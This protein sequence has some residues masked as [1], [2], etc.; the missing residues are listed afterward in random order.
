MLYCAGSNEAVRETEHVGGILRRKVMQTERMRDAWWL[1]GPADRAAAGTDPAA[2]LSDGEAAARLARYGPNQL[3]V[4]K[5]DSLLLEYLLRFRNPL[6]IILLAAS[7]I[8]AFTGELVNFLIIIVIVLLSVTLDFVQ[9]YRA[10]AAAEKLRDSVALQTRVTRGGQPQTIPVAAI[11]PGDIVLL[12][13]GDRIPADG[14][15]LDA[16]DFFVKQALLTG[17]PYPVE[18]R[19]GTLPADATEL[20][21]ASNAVF[22]GTSVISGSAR[23]QVMR[24]G[25]ASALGTI[26]ASLARRPP[27]T[28]F[29]LGARRFGMLIMR[30]TML[31][32]LFV[33]FVNTLHHRPLLE[34][35]LFAVA[36]AVGL[37]PELLPM[38]ISVTLSRGAIRM[39]RQQ[40]IVKRVSAIHDL[41]AMDVLCTDKTGTLTEAK[42]AM[43]LHVDGAGQPSAHVL[44]LAYLNSFFETGLKSPLDE[45][46][47]AYR[48]IDVRGWQK[49]DEVPF[50]FERRRVS[51]LLD[52]GVSRLLVV[53]GAAEEIVHLCTGYESEPGAPARD[54]DAA[55]SAAIE[56][57]YR[58]LEEDG[59]RVLGIAWRKVPRDHP[60]AVVSDETGLILAGF[61]G[62]LDPPKETAAP[63]LAALRDAGVSI[64]IVTGDSD[65][66]TRHLCT[67]LKLPVAGV[68]TGHEIAQL[69]DHAL[70]ARVESAN[71]FCRI[72]PT[73]KNR[74]ILALKA[75]GHV[76][77]YLGDGINDAPSLHSADVGLSVDSAVDVAKEAADMILL[78]QDLQVLHAGVME[79][80]RTFG[81]IMKYIMMGTSSNFGNMFSMAGAS[82]FLPF[83]PMLPTQILLNNILY[84]VSEI[85]IPLDQVDEDEIRRPRVLDIGF[86]RN[87][88]LAVGPISSVFDFLTFYLLLAVF[89]AD[90]T[91]FHTGWFIESLCTQVMVIFVIRTRGNPLRSR[92]HPLLAAVSLAVVAVAV[93]LPLSPLGRYFGLAAPPASLYAVVLVLVLCYLAA[94]QA[95]KC[96]F[97]RRMGNAGQ[98]GPSETPRRPANPAG[99]GSNV[100][101]GSGH[102]HARG[103][104]PLEVRPD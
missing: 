41:G 8:S 10:N 46:I 95:V 14:L 38:V 71:L 100:P 55:A 6:V 79:G 101:A 89:H 42:I 69:D 76:V 59:M 50:D 91:L 104:A 18:K 47:L 72:N 93:L 81:N 39:A 96:A 20:E 31:M 49:V 2:G 77:G 3:R 86:I 48:H 1:S 78:Q 12:S 33:L 37:T 35:F 70:R 56:T 63:A 45:A 53:K 73:E 74:V 28:S 11:V 65:L 87:F 82:L 94:V 62:F 60:H 5:R 83:L 26:A 4:R 66:V 99:P 98:H 30:L 21:D 67:Q 43:A 44:E 32:V 29:E 51:V 34:S 36:L 15:V 25:S 85:P 58:A 88:M 97:Y 40:T 27:P 103:P 19:P 17:E 52:D 90:E 80:R 24:T 54:L 57:R 7:A 9:E 22:M 13:A 23:M 84:D 68:L 92:P 61:A 64:K 102:A 16:R 75:R